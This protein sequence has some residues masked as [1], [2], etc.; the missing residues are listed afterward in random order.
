MALSHHI[1]LARQYA[2][3]A[4]QL[5]ESLRGKWYRKLAEGYA[6]LAE[7]EDKNRPKTAGGVVAARQAQHRSKHCS[8]A[9]S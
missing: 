2:L 8:A 4:D 6:V 1:T 5:G 7:H 3:M 9:S